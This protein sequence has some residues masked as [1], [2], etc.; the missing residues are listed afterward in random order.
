MPPPPPPPRL[1]AGRA[2]RVSSSSSSS[3]EDRLGSLRGQTSQ[4]KT[5]PSPTQHRKRPR[6]VARVVSQNVHNDPKV[7][8]TKALSALKSIAQQ[9][10]ERI[11]TTKHNDENV[12][13]LSTDER[14][15]ETDDVSEEES[16][17]ESEEESGEEFG[18]EED[19]EEGEPS[20]DILR[21]VFISREQRQSKQADET[22]KTVA[23]ARA[24]K[25]E[26]ER[27]EET[28]RI[29]QNLMEEEERN[30][31]GWMGRKDETL[32]DDEDK[33]EDRER[34]FALWRVRE[35]KRILRDKEQ[36][37][38]WRR[39]RSGEKEGR[40]DGELRD[41][42]VER[43]LKEGRD[44]RR[45]DEGVEKSRPA[46]LQKYYKMG[47]FFLEK[48]DDG[49]FLEDVYNRDYNQGTHE[50]VVNRKVLPTPM[51]VRRGEF[52][53]AG[54]SKYTHLANEDTAA[55]LASE[56]R[57]DKELREALERA[58]KKRGI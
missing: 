52:G 8:E 39:K 42:D 35:L 10:E 47:P 33:E 22:G 41:S 20:N 18:D 21:P 58:D 6:L 28:L 50:D 31:N 7:S 26:E 3:D 51:Q 4:Q 14:R 9:F 25:R 57:E 40:N 15:E 1:F 24:E 44:S 38:E 55:R 34:E 19:V 16:D 2:P 43:K 36:L 49:R 23:R 56:F 27:R 53:K 13:Q 12:K 54:R 5:S 11:N 30:K 37:E 46:F 29:V 32:P 45:E 48:G 17:K